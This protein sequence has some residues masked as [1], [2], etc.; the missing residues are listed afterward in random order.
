MFRVILAL[1]AVAW[2][3]TG[4]AIAQTIHT[5]DLLEVSVY[6]D[7]K[8]DRRVV[9]APDGM[10]AFPLAG[11]LKASGRTLQDIEQALKSRLQKNYSEPL[12]IT[13]SLAAVNAE[14]EEANKP[15]V[16]V[17]GEVLRP[18]PYPILRRTNVAQ[19]LSLAGGVGPFAATRR[20]QIHRRINGADSILLFNYNAY[21]DGTDPMDTPSLRSGD[22][23]VVPERGLFE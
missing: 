9:V 14:Q 10:I 7:P 4:S 12:N 18:G 23:V 6:Q 21:Q 19:A 3:M 16:Y 13:V 11:H 1:F 2:A 17:T 22:V 20:I 8:L 5:G 15:R